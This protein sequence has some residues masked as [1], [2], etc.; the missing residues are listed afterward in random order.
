MAA[1]RPNVSASDISD[2]EAAMTAQDFVTGL[3]NLWEPTHGWRDDETEAAKPPFA[4]QYL[5]AIQVFL[6]FLCRFSN[7]LVFLITSSTGRG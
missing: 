2:K 1:A 5:A 4:P 6:Q 7:S 3:E